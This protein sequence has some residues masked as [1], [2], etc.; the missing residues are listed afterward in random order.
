MMASYGTFELV[1]K[2]DYES[3]KCEKKSKEHFRRVNVILGRERLAVNEAA[4][5][6][7]FPYYDITRVFFLVNTKEPS[8]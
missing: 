3:A 6:I 5:M 2:Y 1:L 4:G 8:K 7:F